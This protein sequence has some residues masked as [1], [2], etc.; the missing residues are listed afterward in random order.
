MSGAWPV[1]GGP[2]GFTSP[3]HRR[4]YRI[5]KVDTDKTPV[6]GRV[7]SSYEQACQHVATR[8]THGGPR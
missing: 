7:F 8:I 6:V 1:T 2:V 4:P 5:A 3:K